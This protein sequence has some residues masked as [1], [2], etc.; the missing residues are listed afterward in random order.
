MG[1]IIASINWFHAEFWDY[2]YDNIKDWKDKSYYYSKTIGVCIKWNDEEFIEHVPIENFVDVVK[3]ITKYHTVYNRSKTLHLWLYNYL[4][5]KWHDIK[6]VVEACIHTWWIW[7]DANGE[8]EKQKVEWYYLQSEIWDENIILWVNK[9]E[10]I[11]KK[12][13]DYDWLRL[14]FMD[15]Y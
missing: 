8:K 5:S 2:E 1:R 9:K 13:E 6:W 3:K 4:K 14:R 7:Y 11:I 12:Y 10:H 15:I